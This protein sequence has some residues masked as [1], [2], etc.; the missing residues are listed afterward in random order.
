MLHVTVEQHAYTR[1]HTLTGEQ[2]TT[3]KSHIARRSKHTTWRAS[4]LDRRRVHVPRARAR[5]V[6]TTVAESQDPRGAQGCC[7]IR[8]TS[9]PRRPYIAFT[10]RARVLEVGGGGGARARPA[11]GLR[12]P[13]QQ[14]VPH[15]HAAHPAKGVADLAGEGRRVSSGRRVDGLAG[16][17]YHSIC[18][19][20]LRYATLRYA[21]LCYAMLC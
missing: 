15:R 16:A 4:S 2:H 6:R 20:T 18:Y 8:R 7:D 3:R 11:C 1:R 19:A 21:M 9:A 13:R 10:H 17:G 14:E 5:P 12:W